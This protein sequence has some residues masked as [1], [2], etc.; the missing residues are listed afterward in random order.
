[1]NSSNVI[2]FYDLLYPNVSH[3]LEILKQ[4]VWKKNDTFK[5][6]I[7]TDEKEREATVKFLKN[8]YVPL[9]ES[10]FIEVSKAKKM[11][12]QKRI[13]MHNNRSRNRVP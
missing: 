6:R 12:M 10:S 5:Y 13:H 3:D 11:N 4:H 2:I 7:Y 9:E 1:M 8:Y